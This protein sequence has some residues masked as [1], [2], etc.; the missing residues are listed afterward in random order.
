MNCIFCEIAAGKAPVEII[1]EDENVLSFL[2]IKPLNIGHTLV[3]PKRHYENYLDLPADELRNITLISQKIAAKIVKAFEPDGFN[4]I[5][6]SG[7]AAGQ[8]IFHFHYHIIP[9][10]S[11]DKVK[12]NIVFKSYG[13]GEM[14]QI[15]E[16][17]KNV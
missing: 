11:D 6:N 14:K 8:S 1:Y 7:K 12:F 13:N 5:V 2:D 9:R 15:A 17:I 3:I 10:Y 16:K 4:I